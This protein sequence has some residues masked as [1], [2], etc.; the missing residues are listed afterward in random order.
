LALLSKPWN[1]ARQHP[2][3]TAAVVVLLVLL[4]AA[5]IFTWLHGFS[6]TEATDVRAAEHWRLAQ[7][8]LADREFA[9]AKAHLGNCLQTWPLDAEA[10][11]LMARAS[12]QVGDVPAWQVYLHRAEALQWPREDVDLERALR[13]AQS[14]DFTGLDD[15]LLGY[16]QSASPNEVLVLEA[17]VKGYLENNDID[18]ALRWTL[19]WMKRYP[20]DWEPHLLR[21]RAFQQALAPTASIVGEYR[22]ALE[23]KPNQKE[24]RRQLGNVLA[25]HA[26][27]TE[28]L[29][30][31]QALL[32]T[33]PDDSTA[34]LGVALCQFKLGN[35][36]PAR[37]ILD[38]LLAIQKD[39]PAVLL[40]RAQVDLALDAPQEALTRVRRAQVLA[41]REAEV[42]LVLTEVLRRM[43]R[44]DEALR[45]ERQLEELHKQYRKLDDL[46]KEAFTKP[47]N[48]EPRYEAGALAMSLGRRAEAFRWYRGVLQI[49]PNHRATC[50][51]LAN[52]YAT[53]GDARRAEFYRQ[54]A[55]G[56][57]ATNPKPTALPK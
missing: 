10:N 25:L 48:P 37:E 5:G 47:T 7:Q 34:L 11:F 31:F 39:D 44:A 17:L 18:N 52:L 46:T 40:L 20:D 22:R 6:R 3:R 19:I 32:D 12:S 26:D 49:D 50:R 56:P 1:T 24:T 54:K 14:G 15:K 23:L 35:L 33:E 30:A 51:A 45:Y 55:E 38:K 9:K 53:E 2:R 4:G 36:Q 57:D 8:A 28:A 27:Y 16:L 29:Q 13:Q 21:G 43:D 41:P 42:L